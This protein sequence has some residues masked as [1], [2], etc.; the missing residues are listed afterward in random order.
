V[1]RDEDIPGKVTNISSSKYTAYTSAVKRAFLDCNQALDMLGEDK[2]E[3]LSLI[4]REIYK[5]PEER[6]ISGDDRS[7]GL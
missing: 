3:F 5:Y 7:P 4:T 6:S 1:E 2:K